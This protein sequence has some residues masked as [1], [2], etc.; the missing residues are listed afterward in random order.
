MSESIYARPEPPRIRVRPV[1][2]TLA[3]HAL[4]LYAMSVNWSDAARTTTTVKPVPRVINA[5]L[6][7][8][9]ALQPKPV[10][11]QKPAAKPAPRAV[12]PKA[13][14]RPQPAQRQSRPSQATK[15]APAA[16]PAPRVQPKAQPKPA[17]VPQSEPAPAPPQRASEQELAEMARSDIARALEQEEAIAAAMTA[18]EMTA[19]YAALI[20]QTVMNYW[21]RPPSARNGMEALLAIRLIPTGEVV[22]VTV[23][24]SSGSEAFDRSAVNAVQKAAAFPEL[25]QLPSRE[26]ERTFRR[27]SLLFR[28][29][30]LR[31]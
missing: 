11:E 24:R 5:R 4:L 14:S 29:E 13:S 9:S 20:Q 1:L 8:V 12:K 31:Y 26:F 6:V 17:P 10:P 22:S 3:L 15:P 18:E 25:Q 19:S 7:D 2:A 21:S 16:N 27:F 28:P 30:D 23:E